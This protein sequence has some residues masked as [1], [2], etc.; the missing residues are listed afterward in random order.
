MR[1]VLEEERQV[2]QD[3]RHHYDGPK[4]LVERHHS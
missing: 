1:R 2:V 4:S 3:E